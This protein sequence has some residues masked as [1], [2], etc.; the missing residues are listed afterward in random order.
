[1]FSF[2]RVFSQSQSCFRNPNYDFRD[3]N[4]RRPLL[5]LLSPH[6]EVV[7]ALA[8]DTNDGTL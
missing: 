8:I 1:M 4:Q 6:F 3:C 5:N 7:E 2:F